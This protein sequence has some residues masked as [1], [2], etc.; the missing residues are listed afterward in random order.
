M[1]ICMTLPFLFSHLKKIISQF[2]LYY[3]I[4]DQSICTIWCLIILNFFGSLILYIRSQVF[5]FFKCSHVIPND[6]KQFSLITIKAYAMDFYS[7]RLKL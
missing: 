4:C 7:F 6:N 5:F 3:C 2:L 1:I